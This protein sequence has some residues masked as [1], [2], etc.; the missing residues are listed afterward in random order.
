MSLRNIYE[1]DY[2]NSKDFLTNSKSNEIIDFTTESVEAITNK[3]NLTNFQ[4]IRNSMQIDS[5]MQMH[6]NSNPNPNFIPSPHLL[7]DTDEKDESSSE[8]IEDKDSF[9]KNSI[10]SNFHIKTID[11]TKMAAYKHQ[12]SPRRKNTLT[13]E[14]TKKP[15]QGSYTYSELAEKMKIKMIKR[16]RLPADISK[17]QEDYRK[18]RSISPNDRVLSLKIIKI[19]DLEYIERYSD[20]FPL[21]RVRKATRRL[22]R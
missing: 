3:D 17:I 10:R 15:H 2:Q 21:L 11:D 18:N 12:N 14:L 9:T 13:K 6:E 4:G 19:P 1:L 5:Q 7:G 20:I 22:F 8:T 16:P